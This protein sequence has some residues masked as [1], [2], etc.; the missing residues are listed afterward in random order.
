MTY[1]NMLCP[2]LVLMSVNGDDGE[3]VP[4]AQPKVYNASTSSVQNADPVQDEPGFK[5][6]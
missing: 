3:L 4:P 5:R 6:H 1:T 2:W